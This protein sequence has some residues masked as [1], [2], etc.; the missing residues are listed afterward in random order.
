MPEVRSD[1]SAAIAIRLEPVTD[2]RFYS[3]AGAKPAAGTYVVVQDERCLEFGRVI[4]T[5]ES[6]ASLNGSLLRAAREDDRIAQTKNT[7]LAKQSLIQA[8]DRVRARG[9]PMKLFAARYS[10][11]RTRVTFQFVAEGRVDFRELLHDLAALFQARIELR[12]VGAREQ[13]RVVGGTGPCGRMTC[14]ST[15]LTNLKPI[16]LKMAHAQGLHQNPNK[17]TG[18]C[19]KLMCCLRYELDYYKSLQAADAD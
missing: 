12:Q 2:P 14:C 4:E 9:L 1:S 8:A 16:S 19:G 15:F 18:V 13:T 10:F 11:D 6:P 17:V 3:C 5:A 7:L